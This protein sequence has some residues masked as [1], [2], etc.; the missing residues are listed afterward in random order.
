VLILQASVVAITVARLVLAFAARAPSSSITPAAPPSSIVILALVSLLQM[1]FLLAT[2]VVSA[3]WIYRV[4]ANAHAWRPAMRHSPA[5]AVGWFFVPVVN[6]VLPYRAM[7]EIWRVSAPDGPR[8]TPWLPLWWGFAL[9]SLAIALLPRLLL[10]LGSPM[11]RVG[12]LG[13]AIQ[14]TSV[15]LFMAVVLRLTKLQEVRQQTAPFDGE[16]GEALMTETLQ[17]A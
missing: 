8:P 4:S 10:I 14:L 1:L 3:M 15:G 17:S 12:Y 7:A 6:L 9:A 5:G 16:A 11:M 13:F 2:L